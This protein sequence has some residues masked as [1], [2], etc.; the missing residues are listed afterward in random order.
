MKALYA[1]YAELCVY[2]ISGRPDFYWVGLGFQW[3]K[4]TNSS[5]SSS[6]ILVIRFATIYQVLGGR[7]DLYR[8]K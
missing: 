2:H 7:G 6:D 3:V 4:S 5:L 8:D 1:L